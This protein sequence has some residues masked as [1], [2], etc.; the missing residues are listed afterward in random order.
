MGYSPTVCSPKSDKRTEGFERVTDK[1]N[2][3]LRAAQVAAIGGKEGAEMLLDRALAAIEHF[4][5]TALAL[6]Q[7][8]DESLK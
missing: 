8:I 7:R 6:A 1:A 4:K 3:D 2:S 5:E